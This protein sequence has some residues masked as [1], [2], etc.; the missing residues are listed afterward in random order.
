MNSLIVLIT[1]FVLSLDACDIYDEK[2]RDK[3]VHTQVKNCMGDLN[4]RYGLSDYVTIEKFDRMV[5]SKC[6]PVDIYPCPYDLRK[7]RWE[8]GSINN[9]LKEKQGENEKKRE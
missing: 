8:G 9:Y 6:C 5:D 2:I 4:S 1:F 7:F 3:L